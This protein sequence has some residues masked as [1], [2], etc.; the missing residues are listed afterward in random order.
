MAGVE[1]A[2]DNTTHTQ[3]RARSG[4]IHYTTA[5]SSRIGLSF[6]PSFL[7]PCAQSG[8]STSSHLTAHPPPIH[9]AFRPPSFNFLRNLWLNL[10]RN[11]LVS[12][13]VFPVP[14]IL[15][16]TA[17]P[18]RRALLQILADGE[19]TISPHR[20]NFASATRVGADLDA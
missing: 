6:V 4:A 7:G 15:E 1:L 11:A 18:P 10:L 20:H 14:D 9:G 8:G 12:A 3:R 2:P 13:D 17:E 5:G 16:T 19:R